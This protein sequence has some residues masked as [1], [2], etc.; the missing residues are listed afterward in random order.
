MAKIKNIEGLSKSDVIRELEQGAQF[1]TFQYCI[2][3][4]FM[5]YRKS[6][7]VYFVKAGE[8][9][10]RFGFKYTLLTFVLGWWGIPWGPI[11]S[12]GSIVMNIAG[13]KVV[14]KEVLSSIIQQDA[15]NSNEYGSPQTTET[16]EAKKRLRKKSYNSGF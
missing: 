8:S 6:S 16:F 10:F 2:S 3:I 11:Y 12:L 5:T 1:V 14:T 4:I 9:S 13:G 15:T 7:D